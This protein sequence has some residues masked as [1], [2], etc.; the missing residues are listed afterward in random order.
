M[1]VVLVGP[2]DLSDWLMVERVVGVLTA[3]DTAIHSGSYSLGGK[4]DRIVKRASRARRP[5]VEVE[6]P[7][8]PKYPQAEAWVRLAGQFIVYHHPEVV[9]QFGDELTGEVGPTLDY[10]EKAHIPVLTAEDFVRLRQQR[11]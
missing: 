7:E 4:V 1:K 11:G 5:H 6:F 9:V 3:N 8:V 2:P 10:A